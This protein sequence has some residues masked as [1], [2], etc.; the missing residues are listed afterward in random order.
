MSKAQEAPHADPHFYR[1]LFAADITV[2]NR[3]N[4]VADY[5][6]K[7]EESAKRQNKNYFSLPKKDEDEA[8]PAAKRQKMDELDPQ[9][10]KQ[11]KSLIE[12]VN[13]DRDREFASRARLLLPEIIL[14]I[15]KKNDDF[16]KAKT[17]DEKQLIT[18]DTTEKIFASLFTAVE[19]FVGGLMD[20]TAASEWEER[21][22]NLL[23]NLILNG[24]HDDVSALVT[25]LHRAI[26]YSSC[27]EDLSLKSLAERADNF[28]KIKQ[29]A[30]MLDCPGG[31][32]S[33]LN[34][35]YKQAHYPDYIFNEISFALTQ[36]LIPFCLP[37]GHEHIPSWLNFIVH[38]EE[39]QDG[40]FFAAAASMS[41]EDIR[42]VIRSLTLESG[43]LLAKFIATSLV[44]IINKSIEAAK[45]EEEEV[46]KGD[47]ADDGL[48][49]ELAKYR[50]LAQELL[51]NP[52]HL[53]RNSSISDIH[54][55]L[56]DGISEE[57][58]YEIVKKYVDSVL[59]NQEPQI[60]GAAAYDNSLAELIITINSY[61]AKNMSIP[62]WLRDAA[63]KACEIDVDLSN[64]SDKTQNDIEL[65]LTKKLEEI[66]NQ[67]SSELNIELHLLKLPSLHQIN[68]NADALVVKCAR[69]I[70]KDGD[71]SFQNLLD[72]GASCQILEFYLEAAQEPLNLRP[73]SLKGLLFHPQQEDITSLLKSKKFDLEIAECFNRAII[74]GDIK[75]LDR[76]RESFSEIVRN[77]LEARAPMPTMTLPNLNL[78]CQ[79]IKNEHIL[80]DDLL[81]ERFCKDFISILLTKIL[82]DE[83]HNPILIFEHLLENNDDK[84]EVLTWIKDNFGDEV[85]IYLINSSKIHNKIANYASADCK[86]KIFTLFDNIYAKGNVKMHNEMAELNN[87]IAKEYIKAENLEDAITLHIRAAESG[88]SNSQ[89]FMVYS[90]LRGKNGLEIDGPTALNWLRKMNQ[91]DLDDH[92]QGTVLF[93]YGYLYSHDY[94]GIKKN[95]PAALNYFENALQIFSNM[96]R[97]ASITNCITQIEDEINRVHGLKSMQQ[98]AQSISQEEANPLYESNEQDREL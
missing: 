69:I 74:I 30:D 95:L 37:Q 57:K 94:E 49:L 9:I 51:A 66:A 6:L 40:T 2:F 34:L 4:P 76:Y 43:N 12:E 50:I 82:P 16:E 64:F 52:Y 42:R 79:S 46:A 10:E 63:C 80:I 17:D 25:R 68:E 3:Y 61:V 81:Y 58:K 98:P 84:Y 36:K 35:I 97:N 15:N 93:N 73:L 28:V 77:W 13:D 38:G 70:N 1:Y 14:I 7:N 5:A 8:G 55:A 32:V 85:L 89:E 90:C 53:I 83:D 56:E 62:I 91:F 11:L 65:L 45:E 88:N 67:I 22:K 86:R 72:A 19:K 20:P 78:L 60:A 44:K 47:D 31:A 23:N 18:N 39:G 96:P 54:E 29:S 41:M 92:I 26:F 21:L 24:F 87:S 71:Y 27:N 59:F 33:A 48:R 75:F